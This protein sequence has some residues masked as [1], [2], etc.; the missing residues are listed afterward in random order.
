MKDD[1][2]DGFIELDK[3][4]E[5][6]PF[7]VPLTVDEWRTRD[8]PPPDRLIGE[9]F[10]TTSRVYMS[11]DTGL[12]KTSLSMALGV[13]SGAGLDFLRWRVHRQARILYIDG[14]MSR[15]LFRRRINEAVARLG[16][17]TKTRFLSKED[18]PE[19]FPPLNTQAGLAFLLQLIEYIGGVDGIMFDNV[20]ALLVG[21]QKEELTWNA[22]LPL[23]SELTKRSIG[24]LWIDHTGHDATRGY[25]SKTKQWRMDTVIHLT[26]IAHAD[27][28]ISFEL[29]FHKARERTPETRADF[30]DVIISLVD[31]QWLE[32]GGRRQPGKP[33][34][35]E[36]SVL[37]V[38]DELLCGSNVVNHK[39]RRAVHTDP[40]TEEC[41]RQ[42]VVPSA[43]V[44][45][46]CRSRLVHKNLIQCDGEL[47]WKP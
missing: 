44:F 16:V 47:V 41:L 22:V 33:S 40:W 5:D 3:D 11:A 13:H 6:S 2:S 27:T 46:T 21:D 23:V 37:R 1:F 12:G 28:D 17:P 38:F 4:D 10:T 34:A 24:Q 30:E 36:A 32:E 26:A 20:M 9:W 25:G 31:N 43:H 18:F 45:R 35:Q 29:K 14:E 39:G 19:D 42:G 15:R 7:A 8:L